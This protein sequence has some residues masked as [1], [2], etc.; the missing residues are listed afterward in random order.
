MAPR[1]ADQIEE[2]AKPN[3]APGW[4][5]IRVELTGLCG[6]DLAIVAG[7][8]QRAQPPLV[9]GHEMVGTVETVNGDGPPRG[10]RVAVNP[11]LPCTQ[12]WPC[13]HNLAH[14][15]RQLQLV[16]IDRDGSLADF[17]TAPISAL[18]PMSHATPIQAAV[19]VEPLAV[20]IHAVRQASF[21]SE[22]AVMIFGAGPIG[23]LTGL[24][25]QAAG[26]GPILV[27]EPNPE[28]RAVAQQAGLH[29]IEES[30]P[31]LVDAVLNLTNNT[32]ADVTFD[33]AGHPAVPPLLS[34]VTREHGTIVVAGLHHQPAAID[35]H[36]I[37]FSEQQLIG[38]RVYTQQTSS[39]QQRPSKLKPKRQVTSDPHPTAGGRHA[40]LRVRVHR[41][42]VMKVMLAS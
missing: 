29:S 14:T 25:A 13:R 28:R 27:A 10:V 33:T 40:G 17:V 20:A 8:H 3:I 19:L 42:S 37:T 34:A 7:H 26:A 5:L 16:G 21:E 41:P 30:G 39:Q 23:I 1:T 32:G 15:C 24:V 35:L 2:R 36:A 31:D 22:T 6:T 11:L 12:C 18:V 38:S 4:A 9:L